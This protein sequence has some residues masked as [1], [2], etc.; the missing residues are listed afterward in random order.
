MLAIGFNLYAK[1]LRS[2][3]KMLKGEPG[4]ERPEASIDIKIDAYIPD[5]YISDNDMKI[6]IYKR[7]RDAENLEAVEALE[8]ELADRFGR[9]PGE[10][11]GL[12]EVQA[13]RVV[14]ESA[15]V[16]RIGLSRGTVEAEFAPGHEPKPGKLR[17]ALRDCETALEFDA[18]GG[19]VVRFEAPRGRREALRLGRK[20]LKHFTGSDKL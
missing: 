20:V 14:C 1:L 15:G 16:R 8:G 11:S 13:L 4:K 17:D 9:P 6:D 2:A 12:L 19:L 3:V 7:I 10:V 18:R 5:S